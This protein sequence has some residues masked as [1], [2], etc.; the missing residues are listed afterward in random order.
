MYYLG[1]EEENICPRSYLEIEVFTVK[2]YLVLALL[3]IISITGIGANFPLKEVTPGLDG[4]GKTVFLGTEIEEF[5]VEIVGL[6]PGDGVVPHYVM[7]KVGGKALAL[8]GVSE[9]M[10][11]SPIYIDGKLLGAISYGFDDIGHAYGLVTPIESMEKLLELSSGLKAEIR[12]IDSLTTRPLNAPLFVSGFGKRS[13]QYLSSQLG[14]PLSKGLQSGMTVNIPPEIAPGA[15]LGVQLVKGD[16]TVGSY[17]TLT[18]VYDDGRFLGFGHS[19]LS[20]GTTSFLATTSY[21]HATIQGQPNT[22][23]LASLG[24]PVGTISQDRGAGVLGVFDRTPKMIPVRV[25]TKDLDLGRQILTKAEVI[26]DNMLLGKLVSSTVLEGF[27]RGIDRVGSGTSKVRFTIKG[28]GLPYPLERNN[29]FYTYADIAALSLSE[30]GE[31]LDLLL[32][33]DYYDI[34]LSEVTVE[35][36]FTEEKNTAVIVG[37]VPNTQQVVRGEQVEIEVQIRPFRGESKTLKVLLPIP[38]DIATGNVRVMVRPGLSIPSYGFGTSSVTEKLELQSEERIGTPLTQE[39]QD[40]EK[41]LK[42]FMNREK[43]N[44]IVVEFYPPYNDIINDDSVSNE[45]SLPIQVRVETE[46]VMEG[47]SAW[48]MDI[49]AESSEEYHTE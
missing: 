45:V 33:N 11:G 48:E 14:Y 32:Y 6:I 4:I 35:A 47:D 8:G 40:W 1:I 27:D 12:K 2:K 38:E 17:G 10:S 39:A 24:S 34:K 18:S 20:R 41:V 42:D 3:F 21:V 43:N 37:A 9:G 26:P 22:Y 23:K 30:V 5:P 16:V 29:Y 44:E 19:I 46:Y 13:Q 49:L 28:E 15:A 7:I 31:V 36:D 25:V